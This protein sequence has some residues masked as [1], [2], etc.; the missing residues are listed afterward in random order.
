MVK[1]FLITTALEETW[2]GDEPVLFLGEWCRR[3]SRKPQWERLDA[4]LLPYHWDDRQKLRADYLYLQDLYERLLGELSVQLNEMH[5]VDHDIRYWRILI[6]PWLGYFTQALF[7]RWSSVQQAAGTYDLSGTIVLAGQEERLIPRDM[8]EFN[9]LFT[10]DEW[11]HCLYAFI[12]RR[13]T[14]VACIERARQDRA[15]SPAREQPGH[16]GRGAKRA[17]AAG[18][19]RAASCLTRERDAFLMSTYLPIL[20]EIRMN[21]RLGQVPQLWRPEALQ[22]ADVNP[23]RR[24]WLVRGDTRSEFE[25]CAR[26]LIPQQLP[27]AY[28]E[29]YGRLAR[30][31]AGLPW[32]RQPSVIWTS[33]C[34]ISDDVFKAWA[35]EKVEQ[36][37]PLVIGQHGGHYG[38]GRWSFSE[39]HDLAICDRYLSWGWTEPGQDKIRPIG[40]LKSAVPRQAAASG[41]SGIL[42]VTCALPRYAYWMYSVFVSRQF[43]DY[44]RDQ[45]AFVRNLPASIQA[46]LSVRLHPNDYGWDQELRWK[47]QFPGLRLDNGVGH[48]E[49]SLRQS[50]LVICTYNAT[51]YLESFAMNVPTILFWNPDHWE[52]RES[53]MP[54][55]EGLRHAGVLHETAEGAAQ[56]VAD[57]WSDIEGWWSS[58]RVQEAVARFRSRFGAVPDQVRTELERVLKEP[59][60]ERVE[61]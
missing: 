39:E 5:A 13:H 57:I 18:F 56:T 24:R 6:G 58:A 52:L 8:A 43:L 22:T 49:Q 35:A 20:D 37:A 23:E 29:G 15:S 36:G 38:T 9:R 27:S 51:T 45:C 55:F 10:G 12:L 42:L 41:P 26:E 61:R 50:K 53:A 31:V 44:F 4:E 11:N 16:W 30:Q 60:G 46:E 34:E 33:N 40:Q 59:L 21:W 28:L 1:R 25:E 2:R 54:Y 3:Y 47:D 48:Y 19:A 17:L 32:P 7:D 14:R